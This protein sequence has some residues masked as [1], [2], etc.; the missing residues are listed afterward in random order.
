MSCNSMDIAI[1][2]G[3]SHSW[4][5]LLTN[6]ACNFV[7]MNPAVWIATPLFYVMVPLRLYQHRMNDLIVLGRCNEPHLA[8]LSPLS[9]TLHAT[10]LSLLCVY[11]TSHADMCMYALQFCYGWSI[12]M[13]SCG[14][15]SS[16]RATTTYICSPAEVP[17]SHRESTYYNTLAISGFVCGKCMTLKNQQPC[18]VSVQSNSTL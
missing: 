16:L 1:H 14:K 8:S 13:W 2:K 18:C 3:L 5:E 10:Y 12:D 15:V 7:L 9:Y 11:I 17:S 4:A 6:H